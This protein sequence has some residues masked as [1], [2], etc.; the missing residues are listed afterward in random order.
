M[1]A[2]ACGVSGWLLLGGVVRLLLLLVVLLAGF[3]LAV[4]VLAPGLFALGA[5]CSL[6]A[7]LFR[8]LVVECVQLPT[9]N[10]HLIVRS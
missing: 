7:A 10:P 5:S 3:W 8:L 1:S 2:W 6:L 4:S 9:I